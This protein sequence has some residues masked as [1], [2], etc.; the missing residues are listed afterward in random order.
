MIA[1]YRAGTSHIIRGVQCEMTR[2]RADRLQAHLRAGWVTD[3]KELIKE[4]EELSNKEVRAAAKEAGLEGWDT[5]R[6]GK[7]KEALNGQG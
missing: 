3:P 2:C 7:L 1:L 6:I 5:R 4:E